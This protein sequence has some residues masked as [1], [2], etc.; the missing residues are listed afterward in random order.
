MYC[1]I[2]QKHKKA[3]PPCVSAGK[4]GSCMWTQWTRCTACYRIPSGPQLS[5]LSLVSC[6]FPSL[7]FRRTWIKTYQWMWAKVEAEMDG[8]LVYEDIRCMWVWARKSML[9]CV[10]VPC[11]VKHKTADKPSSERKKA[12]TTAHTWTHTFVWLLEDIYVLMY[13]HTRRNSI[14]QTLLECTD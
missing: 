10:C 6:F 11:R 12:V 8:W 5:S 7:A 3:G 4:Q 2:M 1:C 13:A 14:F 9:L